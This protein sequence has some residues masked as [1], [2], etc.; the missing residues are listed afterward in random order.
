MLSSWIDPEHPNG[1]IGIM[2]ENLI[3]PVLE[4]IVIGCEWGILKPDNNIGSIRKS[5][6]STRL[7]KFWKICI[8]S[9]N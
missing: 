5:G 4:R 2:L 6:R 8:L 3:N 9:I 1:V 7:A